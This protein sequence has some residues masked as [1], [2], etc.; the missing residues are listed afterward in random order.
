MRFG[1][2][3][4]LNVVAEWADKYIDYESL[5]HFIK[6][7]EEEMAKQ[8]GNLLRALHTKKSFEDF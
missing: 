4:G 3:L 8:V 7:T 6:D 5:V 1:K 2:A